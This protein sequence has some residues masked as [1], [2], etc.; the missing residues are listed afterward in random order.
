M[1]SNSYGEGFASKAKKGQMGGAASKANEEKMKKA[2]RSTPAKI[3]KATAE[4]AKTKR[5]VANKT[6]N[7]AM[8]GKNRTVLTKE[9]RQAL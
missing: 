9:L 5:K 4:V 2:N 1:K 8:N 6:H 3:G 7:A